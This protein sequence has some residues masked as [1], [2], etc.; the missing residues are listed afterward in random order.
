MTGLAWWAPRGALSAQA[1]T[2]TFSA[3]Q[4]EQNVGGGQRLILGSGDLRGGADF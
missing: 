1:I 2:T 4:G 3:G